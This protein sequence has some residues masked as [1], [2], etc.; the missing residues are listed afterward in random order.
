MVKRRF[1]TLML[2]REK[3]HSEKEAETACKKPQHHLSMH[4]KSDDDNISNVGNY[5]I[6]I[7]D[8]NDGF[9][10]DESRIKSNTSPFKGQIDLNIQ[11]EREEELSPDSDS[12]SI[13][14]LL[15]DATERYHRQQ[16][17]SN[18]V[19][20]DNSCGNQ[21]KQDGADTL[22]E[23][24]NSFTLSSKN[25]NTDIGSPAPLSVKETPST[26]DTG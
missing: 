21:P 23:K 6:Q 11:P 3:K 1:R 8:G 9:D 20:G 19:G 14:K 5:S 15:H 4:E 10:D 17:L 24:Q 18:S 13:L 16:K 12:G 26:T 7:R 22:T 2:R 25:P